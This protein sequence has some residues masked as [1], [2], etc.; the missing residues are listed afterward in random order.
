MPKI[1]DMIEDKKLE[2][3]GSR[4]GSDDQLISSEDIED[5]IS[6]PKQH[7]MLTQHL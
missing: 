7:K 4:K 5:K 3:K 1:P 6:Q 2:K